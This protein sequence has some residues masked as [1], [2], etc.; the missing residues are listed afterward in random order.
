MRIVIRRLRCKSNSKLKRN[1]YQTLWKWCGVWIGFVVLWDRNITVKLCY[2][3]KLSCL[4]L[5]YL[6]IFP[7]RSI[8]AH[9]DWLSY[10]LTEWYIFDK[11]NENLN[12]WNFWNCR[13]NITQQEIQIQWHSSYSAAF[14]KVIYRERW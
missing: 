2:K 14:I 6:A 7:Y 12:K 3:N 8:C 9:S 13:T 1:P 10:P 5:S 11:M 4:K